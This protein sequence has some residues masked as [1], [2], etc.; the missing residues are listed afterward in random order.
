MD[1]E[2]AIKLIEQVCSQFHGNLQAHQNIQI[3][4]G[5]IKKELQPK[6]GEQQPKL[7]EVKNG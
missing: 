7:E 2:Q 1:K 5:V 3:A 6:V 4:L